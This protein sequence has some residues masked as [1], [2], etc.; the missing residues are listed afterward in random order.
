MNWR[1]IAYPRTSADWIASGALLP[2]SW[3]YGLGWR[4]YEAVYRFGLKRR[5]RF[6]LPI[7][8]VGNL[9][10]GGEGKSP[11]VIELVRL[12]KG[13]GMC[14]AISLSAYGSDASTGTKILLPDQQVLAHLHGDEP[15]EM[16]L[17]HPDVPLILGRNRVGAASAALADGFECLLLDDGFQHLPLGRT[18]DAVIWDDELPNK[19]LIPA[20]PMREPL[21]G[22]TRATAVITPNRAPEG[23]GGPVFS[24]IR[25]YAGVRDV[26]GGELMPT[27]W[28]RGRKVRA[29]CA[30]ARPERFFDALTSLGAD[31]EQRLALP[32]H[33]PLTAIQGSDLPTVVTEK[34]ATKINTE[35]GKFFA[36]SMRVRFNDEEAV[37]A[38]L[39][40]TLSR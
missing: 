11:I 24:F 9:S 10:T 13:L 3:L 22:L 30:I 33:D 4:S 16:R 37:A 35:A 7:L 27:D 19:R 21:S 20:G 32:D 34:D 5:R 23:W 36:L 26:S 28:L 1:R 15:A 14:P 8:G 6:D 12:A 31:V 17:A 29:A 2:L 18:A 38:W 39:K 25:D 40:K